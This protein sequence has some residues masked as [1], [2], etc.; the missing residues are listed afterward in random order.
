ML[1]KTPAIK[2]GVEVREVKTEEDRL[3]LSGVANAMPCTVEIG[4]A[5]LAALAGML[6][7]PAVIGLVL[8]SLFR[9]DRKA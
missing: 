2:L 7:R 4:S 5:E 6:M 8:K 3:V 1:V 9:R